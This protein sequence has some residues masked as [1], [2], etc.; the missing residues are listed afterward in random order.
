MERH[1]NDRFIAI[2]DKYLP[3]WRLLR[4]ELNLALFGHTTWEY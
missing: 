2:M 3:L 4:E 1:H